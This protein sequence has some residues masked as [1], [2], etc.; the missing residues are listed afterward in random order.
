MGIFNSCCEEE[1]LTIYSDEDVI[2]DISRRSYRYQPLT[3]FCCNEVDYTCFM[4]ETFI[5]VA[6]STYHRCQTCK[7]H[8]YTCPIII[9][10]LKILR[11][12]QERSIYTKQQ[13]ENDK[14]KGYYIYEPLHCSICK[15]RDEEWVIRIPQSNFSSSEQIFPMYHQCKKCT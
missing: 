8:F 10:R 2:R 6:G 3:C 9:E 7:D 12:L 5:G 14:L 13:M 1:D 4:K 11:K 15:K